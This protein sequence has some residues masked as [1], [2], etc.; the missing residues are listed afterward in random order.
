MVRGK[1]QLEK[2]KR[3]GQLETQVKQYSK[4]RLERAKGK[5][6]VSNWQGLRVC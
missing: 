3:E 1:G 4:T 2:G 5:Q 6:Q